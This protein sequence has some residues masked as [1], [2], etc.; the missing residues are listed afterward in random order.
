MGKAYVQAPWDADP[1]LPHSPLVVISPHLDDAIL[2]CAGLLSLRRGSTVVT[3][4]TARAK[5][6]D[7]LTDWDRRC[8]FSS[9]EA[10]MD[11]RLAEDREALDIVGAS[12]LGLDFPDSQYADLPGE[13]TPLL[14]ERLFHLLAGL[15]PASVAMPLGL[16]H[17]DHVRVSDAAMMIRDALPA[18]AWF[19]YEDIPY[20]KQAGVVQARLSQLHARGVTATP[21]HLAVD[22]PAKAR[23]IAAYAS[24]LKGLDSTAERLALH[25]TYWRLA[26]TAA[27]AA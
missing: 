12:G 1:P 14:T 6:P 5:T 25:E 8:G 10:A 4:Y 17:S 13:E 23:A 2:S 15:A 18:V 27:D 19:G 7:L 24:Q 26:D 9:A 16:F 11:R 20:R 3:V 21:V 22:V